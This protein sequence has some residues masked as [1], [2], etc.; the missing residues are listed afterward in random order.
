MRLRR[1]ARARGAM[2]LATS[3]I[4]ST[5][6]QISFEVAPGTPVLERG[7][8][9]AVV[10]GETIIFIGGRKGCGRSQAAFA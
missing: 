3:G 1:P 6:R 8:H 5:W 9:A 7:G 4:S 10:D 2:V